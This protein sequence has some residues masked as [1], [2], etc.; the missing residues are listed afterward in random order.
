MRRAA[1]C[2][3]ICVCVVFQVSPASI[4]VAAP[5]KPISSLSLL[6]PSH[7]SNQQ[8]HQPAGTH[9]DTRRT[10]HLAPRWTRSA[11]LWSHK[12]SGCYILGV[13]VGGG[14]FH[15]SSHDHHQSG[16]QLLSARAQLRFC[17]DKLMKWICWWNRWTRV[18][19]QTLL[20][21]VWMSGHS[22]DDGLKDTLM[23]VWSPA[24]LWRNSIFYYFKVVFCLTWGRTQMMQDLWV[25]WSKLLWFSSHCLSGHRSPETTGWDAERGSNLEENCSYVTVY[26]VW[27]LYL[28][29]LLCTENDVFS[30]KK[31]LSEN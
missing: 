4:T 3:C 21:A 12:A 20:T 19:E 16:D 23:K 5:D 18:V 26:I 6:I 25:V 15:F 29:V 2:V 14:V 22:L 30:K 24:A 8:L 1:G 13:C 7:S 10:D 28:K 27:V 17:C 9:E 31:N 11:S